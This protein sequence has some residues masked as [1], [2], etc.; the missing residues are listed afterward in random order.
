MSAMLIPDMITNIDDSIEFP[1]LFQQVRI[2]VAVGSNI[3]RDSLFALFFF[4]V[5]KVSI[6]SISLKCIYYEIYFILHP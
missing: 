2:G 1:K 4:K 3:I 6:F 5:K